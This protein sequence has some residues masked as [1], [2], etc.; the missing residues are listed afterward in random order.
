MIVL[1][2]FDVKQGGLSLK[3]GILFLLAKQQDNAGT[4]QFFMVRDYCP[5]Q[6]DSIPCDP[7]ILPNNRYWQMIL[8]SPFY[9]SAVFGKRGDLGSFHDFHDP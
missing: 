1:L 8:H 3:L 4:K 9:T 7:R 2:L 6:S 5:V